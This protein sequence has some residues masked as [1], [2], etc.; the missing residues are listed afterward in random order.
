MAAR[1][2]TKS[3]VGDVTAD[4]IFDAKIARMAMTFDLDH[5]DA[6][7]A[8]ACMDPFE[9]NHRLSRNAVKRNAAGPG[10]AVGVNGEYKFTMVTGIGDTKV[11][12]LHIRKDA[13]ICGAK[14]NT[15]YIAF[16]PPVNPQSWKMFSNLSLDHAGINS[17]FSAIL[18]KSLRA[19]ICNF[20]DGALA[21]HLESTNVLDL[22]AWSMD[23]HLIGYGF[24]GAL[25]A[26][27]AAKL[28]L[29]EC[30]HKTL[31]TFGAP[32]AGNGER[33][34]A[35]VQTVRRFAHENDPITKL[36]VG[37]VDDYTH[38]GTRL[39]DNLSVTRYEPEGGSADERSVALCRSSSCAVQYAGIDFR[40]KPLATMYNVMPSYLV[41]MMFSNYANQAKGLW[42]NV[43]RWAV[44]AHKQGETRCPWD[45]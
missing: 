36:F 44:L 34:A 41:T 2:K 42:D 7:K 40:T 13:K 35:H 8:L 32:P 5:T 33:L 15:I 4:D 10:P 22:D 11:L 31:V 3:N 26:A 19:E 16:A 28:T 18:S 9:F 45:V 24:G 37:V 1:R 39:R 21:T 38:F 20:I 12:M 6:A 17:S 25:A 29:P 27:A 43:A 14:D 30:L 23:C